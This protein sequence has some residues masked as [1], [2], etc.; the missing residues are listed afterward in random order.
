MGQ[1]HSV[2]NLD[3]RAGY[4]PRSLGSFVKAAEQGESLTPGAALLLLLSDPNGWGGERIAIVG[5]YAEDDDITDS[6]FPAS[7]L[8]ERIETSNGIKNVGWLARKAVEDAGIATFTKKESRMRHMDGTVSVSHH[9]DYSIKD[10]GSEPLDLAM[11]VYNHDKRERVTPTLLGDSDALLDII[12]EG[13]LGGTATALTILLVAS[14]KGGA[15]G[16]GDYDGE[17]PLVG[18]WAGDHVSVSAEVEGPQG[19][20]DITAILR[21]EVMEHQVFGVHYE[22]DEKGRITRAEDAA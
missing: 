14:C 9:Y 20:T 11:T 13:W 16:G 19:Y 2:I 7:E 17:H 6:P 8:W 21:D 12:R 3:K 5:D 4:S 10:F 18:S 15:R 1:Y 22:A